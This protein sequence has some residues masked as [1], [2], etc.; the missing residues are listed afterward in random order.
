MLHHLCIRRNSHFSS[1]KHP[2]QVGRTNTQLIFPWVIVLKTCLLAD[3]TAGVLVNCDLNNISSECFE[4]HRSMCSCVSICI[5]HHFH[6][7]TKRRVE[8]MSWLCSTLIDHSL[9][10]YSHFSYSII[11]Y[12]LTWNVHNH[13]V[14]DWS[15]DQWFSDHYRKFQWTLNSSLGCNLPLLYVT[16]YSI[17]CWYHF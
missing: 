2:S 6:W 14:S 12:S 8:Q 3:F 5:R 4:P 17:V 10:L 13:W 15:G 16:Y 11:Q 1:W 9:R 7:P